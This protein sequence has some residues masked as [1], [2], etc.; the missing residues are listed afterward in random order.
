MA[1]VTAE[2]E[3]LKTSH[4]TNSSR[5]YIRAKAPSCNS[6]LPCPDHRLKVLIIIINLIRTIQT[7]STNKIVLYTILLTQF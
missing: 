4:I 6:L 1:V 5:T 3:L 2:E 7:I